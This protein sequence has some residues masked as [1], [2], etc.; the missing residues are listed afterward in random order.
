MKFF[1]KSKQ[2]KNRKEKFW[3]GSGRFFLSVVLIYMAMYGIN[4]LVKLNS[5]RA[6]NIKKAQIE[7]TG[8]QLLSRGDILDLCDIDTESNAELNTEV[9]SER[10]M[11]SPYVKGVSVT[12]RPP[13]LLNITLDERKP[14]AFIYGKGLNLIDESGF[15]MPVPGNDLLWDLP[16]IS[17]ISESIG[18]RGEISASE[19]AIS[20]VE[21]IKNIRSQSQILHSLIS[22]INFENPKMLKL[23]L[24]RGGAKIHISRE[25]YQ[26]EIHVFKNF[27]ISYLD[28]KKLDDIEYIDLRFEQQLIVKEKA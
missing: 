12:V 25:N 15:I 7:I 28:W 16:I 26:K 14:V 13:K 10:I 1:K 21:I 17:G 22:E 4:I 9:I 18:K 6:T 5:S 8:N 23:Y 3:R 2:A 27:L 19:Q 11:Q 20:A 24:A